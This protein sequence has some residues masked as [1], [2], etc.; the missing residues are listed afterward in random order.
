[1]ISLLLALI[2]LLSSTSKMSRHGWISVSS[3][4]IFMLLVVN[5]LLTTCFSHF[6]RLFTPVISE[7]LILMSSG[8]SVFSSV[9]SVSFG[10]TFLYPY[11]LFIYFLFIFFSTTNSS[12]GNIKTLHT[13]IWLFCDP[14]FF[15]GEQRFGGLFF[16]CFLFLLFF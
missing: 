4:V 15:L 7:F 3:I 2:L 1:M 11:F 16:Y 5:N 14:P 6:P 13:Y 12:E 10:T 8:I 9:L